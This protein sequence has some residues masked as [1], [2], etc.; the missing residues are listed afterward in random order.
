MNDTPPFS[1]F[2]TQPPPA[3]MF[4]PADAGQAPAGKKTRKKRA[5]NKVTKAPK[6]AHKPR[7]DIA[8]QVK[9]LGADSLLPPNKMAT[10]R[11][12]RVTRAPKFDLGALQ[13]FAGLKAEDATMLASFV[14]GLSLVNKKSRAKIMEA[15]AKVFAC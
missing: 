5:P 8:K 14:A 12:A 15:L 7:H 3:P 2:A 6:Q 11:K 13:A 9:T 1:P 10:K 4:D